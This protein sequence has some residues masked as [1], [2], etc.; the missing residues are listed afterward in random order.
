MTQIA[1]EQQAK[2]QKERE[3]RQPMLKQHQA[4]QAAQAPDNEAVGLLVK[5]F[6]NPQA[7]PSA[8]LIPQTFQNPKDKP[9]TKP[10]AKPKSVFEGMIEE[11]KEKESMVEEVPQKSRE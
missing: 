1:V 7:Q 2:V 8:E 6:L 10:K 4:D 5:P 9:K 11:P 3:E